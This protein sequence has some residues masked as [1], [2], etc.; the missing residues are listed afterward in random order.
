MSHG[1]L[2]VT[3]ISNGMLEERK[4]KK[5]RGGEREMDREKMSQKIV[6]QSGIEGSNNHAPNGRYVMT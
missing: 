3:N 2:L 1:I 5:E 4:K 6:E